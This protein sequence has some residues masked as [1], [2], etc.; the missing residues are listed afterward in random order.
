MKT[1]NEIKDEVAMD[2]GYKDFYTMQFPYDMVCEE[3]INEIAKRYA[4]EALKEAANCVSGWPSKPK[5]ESEIEESIL[6]LI[7]ELK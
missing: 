2:H 5:T 7:N 3:D 6:S 4:E 1:I